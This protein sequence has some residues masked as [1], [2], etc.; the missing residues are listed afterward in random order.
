VRQRFLS[1]TRRA[2]AGEL[3]AW[4]A[5]PTEALALVLLVVAALRLDLA[6]FKA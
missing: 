3:D 6:R 2:I 1:L 5:E 4:D